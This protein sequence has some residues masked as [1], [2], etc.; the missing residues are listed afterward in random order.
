[1]AR[2]KIDVCIMPETANMLAKKLDPKMDSDKRFDVIFDAVKDK[3]LAREINKLFE[4]KMLLKV[5]EK[6]DEQF[7]KKISDAKWKEGKAKSLAEERARK[8]KLIYNDDGTVK[9]N[10]KAFLRQTDAE[11]EE[12]AY[13]VFTKKLGVEELSEK[14]LTDLVEGNKLITELK[15]LA[16]ATPEGSAERLAYGQAMV[17]MGK[18]MRS[19]VD[20]L[21]DV[22]DDFWKKFA[23]QEKE[24]IVKEFTEAQGLGKAGVAI[25]LGADLITT[26]VYKSV[27]AALDF[28]GALRQGFKTLSYALAKK[29]GGDEKALDLWWKNVQN[30]WAPWKN[31]TQGKEKIQE[32]ADAFQARVIGDPLYEE[33]TKAKLRIGGIE[34]FFPTALPDHFPLLGGAFKASNESYTILVQ[35]MR[36]DLYKKIRE[37]VVKESGNVTEEQ[38]KDIAKV[39]N[40]ITGAASLGSLE[41]VSGIIN[42]MFFS[43]RF[44]KS[45]VDTFT[46]PFNPKLDPMVRA[47]AMKASA[48]TLA[49]AGTLMSAASMFTEVETDPRSSKFGKM[50]VPGSKDTWIDLTAGLGGYISIASKLVTGQS[51]SSVTG[52][53]KNLGERYGDQTR[54]DVAVNWLAGKAAPGPSQAIQVLRGKDYSGEQPTLTSVPKNLVTPIGASN[55]LEVSG[56]ENMSTALIATVADFLGMSSSNYEKFK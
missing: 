52:K 50:K 8:E 49:L 43:G 13:A 41:S 18:K 33:M 51:K 35:G 40:S 15:E 27:Q 53:V 42:K 6:A 29:A 21:D 38:L 48:S 47:E 34:D 14:Q 37:K 12:K 26:P 19:V 39:A 30:G 5:Q 23:Q 17:S 4:A 55:F 16:E 11:L 32:V 22:K 46:L 54:F 2:K 9:D 20:P 25:K 31:I 1:M 28:S 36:F 44:I 10:F 45:Q 7:I 56:N 24:K 3:E